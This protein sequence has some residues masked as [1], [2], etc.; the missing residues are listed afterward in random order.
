MITAFNVSNIILHIVLISVFI[1]IF[2]FTYGAYLEKEIIKI[3]IEYLINDLIGS[4]KVFLPKSEK[5][6]KHIRDFDIKI[7][8]SQDQKVRKSNNS[9]KIKAFIAIFILV[10]FGL[11]IILAISKVMNRQN[12]TQKQFWLK[13]FKYNI[14]AIIFIGLTEFIFASFFVKK[15]MAINTNKLK[16]SVIDNVI[17]YFEKEDNNH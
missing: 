4:V 12:M 3:Q 13:L 17:N 8:E 15:Y 5:I 11:L 9:I 1:G 16:K 2:F 14:V 7:D 6:N 10:I